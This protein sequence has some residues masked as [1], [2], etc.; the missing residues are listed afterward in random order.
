[1]QLSKH[2]KQFLIADIDWRWRTTLWIYNQNIFLKL[3]YSNSYF[4]SFTA[5][6]IYSFVLYFSHFS[7][8][9]N[10]QRFSKRIFAFSL[11][12]PLFWIS[13]S[14]TVLS[15]DKTFPVRTKRIRWYRDFFILSA[16][17][18]KWL[19]DII[20]NSS[21]FI[22]DLSSV[23]KSWPFIF[24]IRTLSPEW[25]NMLVSETYIMTWQWQQKQKQKDESEIIRTKTLNYVL[26]EP[27]IIY[28]FNRPRLV[29]KIRQVKK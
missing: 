24:V 19:N 14:N 21:I 3:Y 26:N 29:Q 13:S 20:F 23:M 15:S 4:N 9:P 8:D 2:D 17:L 25:G 10:F 7:T 27:D 28:L 11:N 1:M 5:I 6:F 22:S 18:E 12:I 16:G